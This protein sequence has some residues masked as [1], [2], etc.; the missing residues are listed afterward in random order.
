MSGFRKASLR[1]CSTTDADATTPPPS[2]FG[3]VE[4]V[5][6]ISPSTSPSRSALSRVDVLTSFSAGKLPVESRLKRVC[7]ASG[8]PLTSATSE[9]VHSSTKPSDVLP[10]STFRSTSPS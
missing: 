10:T 4:T 1:E 3:E 5:A 8:M 9:T 2:E 7:L 6:S